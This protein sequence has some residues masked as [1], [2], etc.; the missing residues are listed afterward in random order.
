MFPVLRLS[1][2]SKEPLLKI[3]KEITCMLAYWNV[4]GDL[5]GKTKVL[6]NKIVPR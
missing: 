5:G 4:S 1:P 2:A 6:F 3:L